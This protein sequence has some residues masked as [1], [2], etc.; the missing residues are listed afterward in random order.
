MKPWYASK[1]I[2]IN[3]AAA[4]LVALE[5]STGALKPLLPVDLYTTIAI[6]LPMINA[7]LRVVTT[8]GIGK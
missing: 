6:A 8:Q 4:M 1:T 3:T 2:W 7:A 5:A